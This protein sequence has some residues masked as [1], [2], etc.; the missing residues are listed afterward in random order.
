MANKYNDEHDYD[1]DDGEED[2]NDDNNG[3]KLIT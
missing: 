1:D 2:D 3:L